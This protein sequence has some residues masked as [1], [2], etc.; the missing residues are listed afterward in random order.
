MISPQWVARTKLQAILPSPSLPGLTTDTFVR[1]Y[2]KGLEKHDATF[3][4]CL[5]RDLNA[6]YC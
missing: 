4:N 5:P 3:L 2:S 1:A 6:F